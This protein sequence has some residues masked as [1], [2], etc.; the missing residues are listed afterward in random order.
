MQADGAEVEQA[1]ELKK[2]GVG[3]ILVQNA[4]VG[5]SEDLEYSSFVVGGM[6]SKASSEFSFSG[7]TGST[8]GHF[9]GVQA[10]GTVQWQRTK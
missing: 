10:R 5:D 9:G 8:N 2:L 4:C 6:T 1:K 7:L 3:S